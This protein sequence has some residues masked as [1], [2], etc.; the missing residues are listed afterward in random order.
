MILIGEKEDKIIRSLFKKELMTN[1]V[2]DEFVFEANQSF[3]A[4]KRIKK[5]LKSIKKRG[6]SYGRKT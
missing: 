5:F 2:W 6:N 3:K 1:E 4:M